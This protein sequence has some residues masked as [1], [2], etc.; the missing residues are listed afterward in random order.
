[1][2]DLILI[3]V[4]LMG[5]IIGLKRGFILQIVHLTGF[6][7]AFIVAYLYY[8]ELAPKINLWIPYPTFGDP[9]AM[10]FLFEGTNLEEAY[11]KAIAFAMIF[12]AVKILMQ[13]IGS[14][15]DF[16]ANLPILKQINSWA[17]GLLG[18]IEIYLIVFILLYIGALLPIEL[19]QS[20]IQ[21]SFMAKAI[22]QHTP[23][24]SG[25]IKDMWI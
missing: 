14:M 19:V 9:E 7:V 15:L 11:Y 8:A 3:F 17:G 20:N 1:M 13:I 21:D 24:F 22:V 6:I 5:F 12:F 10:K 18:F 4:L 2:F 25:K 16:L 23:I